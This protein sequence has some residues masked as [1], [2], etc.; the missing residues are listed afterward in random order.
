[1]IIDSSLIEYILTIRSPP[2]DLP[3]SAHLPSSST[4]CWS[5]FSSNR[6]TP[7]DKIK[8]NVARQKPSY[9]VWTRQLINNWR[10]KELEIHSLPLIGISQEHQV[11]SYN[12]HVANVVH[13][14]TGPILY[15]SITV[16]PVYL[17][18]R[19]CPLGILHVQWFQQSFSSL[20][21]KVLQSLK[22][23]TK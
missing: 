21:L 4:Y 2:S 5:T 1:M 8:Y 9:R 18:R 14:C 19:S 12:I 13:T 16:S 11:S 15:V 3:S 7:Q 6:A 23:V 17:N 20:F 10:Q 22:R